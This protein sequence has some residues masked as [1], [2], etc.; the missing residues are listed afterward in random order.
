MF[1]LPGIAGLIIFLLIRPQEFLPLLQRV[2]FLHLFTVFAVLGWVIDVRLKRVDP[3]PTPGLPWVVAFLVWIIIGTAVAAPENFTTRVFDVVIL[4]AI[5]GTIAHGVQSFRTFQTLAGVVVAATLFVT[6]VCFHQGLS[7]KQCIGGEEK[8]G[9]IMGR[10]D[11]RVCESL[12][13]C[14]GPDAE[15]GFEYRCEY[16]GLFGTYSVDERVRYR[17]DLQDPN[18][19][20][21][22]IS[23]G[24]LALLIAFMMRKRETAAKLLCLGG[25][26]IAV[27]TIFMTQSRGGLVSAMLVPGVYILRRYGLTGV[28]VAGI[29]AVPI[30]VS[31][32]R[33]GEAAEVST[34]LRYE[35]WGVGLQLFYHHPLFGVGMR[36]FD[37]HHYLTAHNSFVLTLAELGFVGLWMFSTLIYLSFKTLIAGLRELAD[38][39]GTAA[40]QVWGMALLAALAG[41]VFQ[42]LT[43]SF[44]YHAVLWIF[45]GLVGAWG[46]AIRHHRPSFAIRITANDVFRVV[47][48][49]LFFVFIGLP[50]F[51][52]LK[53][54]R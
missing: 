2:P 52:R 32:S 1:A 24:A 53:G 51:L 7:D 4:F 23:A 37:H 3:T 15:A 29:L 40:A 14:L 27:A 10:P 45:L 11:G 39:P 12:E 42:I 26:A 49:C 41:I 17:G 19:V 20:S 33:S 16:V 22:T 43:L 25:A 35:A 5:Y 18:E 54:Q 36:M 48:G 8:V 30:L 9:E 44:A 38:V 31:N 50:I 28:I 34:I 46:S 21:L 47:A 6:L 13:R